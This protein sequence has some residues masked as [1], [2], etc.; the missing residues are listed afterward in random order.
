[1]C[2]IIFQVIDGILLYL[3]SQKSVPLEVNI[4][5]FFYSYVQQTPVTSLMDSW[6]SFLTL[7]REGMQLNL[8]PPGKFLLFQ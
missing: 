1:M 2:L 7:L 4:L 5:Q 3:I 8:S 6:G